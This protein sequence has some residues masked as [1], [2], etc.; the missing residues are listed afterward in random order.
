[1][2]ILNKIKSVLE[3]IFVLTVLM[4]IP[5]VSLLILTLIC[6]I[7]VYLACLV[8]GFSFSWAYAAVIAGIVIIACGIYDAL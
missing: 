3:T 4:F 2:N 7:P 1:M 6:S 5:V 8:F